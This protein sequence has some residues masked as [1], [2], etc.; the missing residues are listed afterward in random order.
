MTVSIKNKDKICKSLSGRVLIPSSKSEAHRYIICASLADKPTEIRV[1]SISS[2]IA[3]TVDCMRALG[4]GITET[5]YG[6]K[7]EPIAECVKNPCLRCRDS[8]STLRFL[9][10]VAASLGADAEFFMEERLPDRPLYPLDEEMKNHGCTLRKEG[11]RLF[12][13]GAMRGNS[14]KIASNISSQF[15]S[16]ILMALPVLDGGTIELTG[17]TESKKYIEMTVC[18]MR[19]FGVTVDIN[20]SVITVSG[21]YKSPGS[22]AVGGDWSGAACWLCAGA[23]SDEG[24]TCVGLD[25]NS[26]QG[27]RRI[28]DVLRDMGADVKINSDAVT[29][30]RAELR[31]IAVNAE[32]IPDLVPVIAALAARADGVTKITGA[33]RLRIKESDRIESTSCILNALGAD[34]KEE[35]DGLTIVGNPSVKELDGGM[36]DSFRDHRIAMS[37][38][39]ASLFCEEDVTVT[40]AEVVSKSYTDFWHDFE[41]LGGKITIE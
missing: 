25:I 14:Y 9:L 7:I 31:G 10:P 30:S 38:A 12:C 11:S 37:A 41:S 17:K 24:I 22:L 27:D 36:V 26:A 40:N 6:F 33:A 39:L 5:E 28:L 3:A 18:A 16:G 20:N 21:K 29:V 15:I 2:D 13:S 34:V 19:A 23:L 32:D 35:I 4:A 1:N 8:G